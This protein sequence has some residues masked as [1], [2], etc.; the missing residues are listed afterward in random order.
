MF[1]AYNETETTAARMLSLVWRCAPAM[2]K[3][4][5]GALIQGN[6]ACR[7]KNVRKRGPFGELDR[8]RAIAL[9]LAGRTRKQIAAEMGRSNETICAVLKGVLPKMKPGRKTGG[10]RKAA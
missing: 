1:S 9:A 7:P 5:G 4:G 10:L 3:K 8:Q 6:D 2:M